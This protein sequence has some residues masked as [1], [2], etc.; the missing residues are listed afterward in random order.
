MS[1][2]EHVWKLVLHLDGCHFHQSQYTCECGAT[3]ATSDERDP[4]IDPYS[5]VWMLPEDCARCQEL[6]D[7][8]EAKHFDEIE[9]PR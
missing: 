2:H 6:W 4:K 1:E 3:R 9:L 5:T 8:M 7:G